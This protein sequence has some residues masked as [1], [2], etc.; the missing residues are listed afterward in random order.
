M[1]SEGSGGMKK[2]SAGGKSAVGVRFQVHDKKT[3]ELVSEHVRVM[4]NK[5]LREAARK[6][7]ELMEKKEASDGER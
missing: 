3:G 7:Q 6:A 5:E 4:G 1:S 2:L